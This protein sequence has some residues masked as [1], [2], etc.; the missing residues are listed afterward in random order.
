M[1]LRLSSICFLSL[2]LA[3]SL[4]GCS[5]P[6]STSQNLMTLPKSEVLETVQIVEIS[7]KQAYKNVLS[8]ARQCWTNPFIIESDPFDPDLGISRVSMRTQD[9]VLSPT[10]MASVVEMRP[11]SANETEIRTRSIKYHGMFLAIS[12]LERIKTI[13]EG[14]LSSCYDNVSAGAQKRYKPVLPWESRKRSRT[15]Q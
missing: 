3:A 2:L 4:N 6:A 12:D 13:S 15:T 10:R 14:K 9:S 8:F 11:K 5:T 7:E 1:S